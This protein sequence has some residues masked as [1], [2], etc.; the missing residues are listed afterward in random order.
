[1]YPVQ[2]GTADYSLSAP[3]CSTIDCV[4]SCTLKGTA[5]SEGRLTQETIT[6]QVTFSIQG[7]SLIGKCVLS[8][9]EDDHD[10]FTK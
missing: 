2:Y 4:Y 10:E 8:E 5:D 6:F 3:N 7:R 1:M 9:R